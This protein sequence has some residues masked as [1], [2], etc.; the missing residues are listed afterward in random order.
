MVDVDETALPESLAAVMPQ[1]WKDRA[2]VMKEAE[3]MYPYIL[4]ADR[5]VWAEDVGTHRYIG[6]SPN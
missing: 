6:P 1:L 5:R 4:E 2:R 3:K